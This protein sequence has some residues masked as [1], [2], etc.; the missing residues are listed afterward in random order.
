MATTQETRKV[1]NVGTERAKPIPAISLR[2]K[3]R[4]VGI[5]AC[6]GRRATIYEVE[7]TEGRRQWQETCGSQAELYRFIAGVCAAYEMRGV[8]L[9]MP[10]MPTFS[11][12]VMAGPI[13]E[14][15]TAEALTNYNEMG[16]IIWDD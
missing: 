3:M 1:A 5:G 11:G 13:P 15:D 7:L 12:D 4:E 2:I 9:A 10:R 16:C 8:P 6:F 14:Q